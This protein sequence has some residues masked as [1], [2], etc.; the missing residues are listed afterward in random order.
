MAD[1]SG[2]TDELRG[3]IRDWPDITQEA[4]FRNRRTALFW[5][6]I[7]PIYV[8]THALNQVVLSCLAAAIV[9]GPDKLLAKIDAGP[10]AK[11]LSK[12]ET[13]IYLL[14]FIVNLIV[15]IVKGLA[16]AI[17]AWRAVIKASCVLRSQA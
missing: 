16:P 17:Q 2:A 1:P 15:Y 6:L 11:P 10:L 12:F 4:I 9:V 14:V 8:A 7:N 13:G 3:L 5:R